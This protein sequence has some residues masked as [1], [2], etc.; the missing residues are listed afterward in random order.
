MVLQHAVRSPLT[1]L[2][3]RRTGDDAGR[4][5]KIWYQNENIISWLD[6]A[7]YVTVPDLICMFDLDEGM[8]QLNP[9]A[10]PGEHVRVI[11]LPAPAE[12][13]TRRGLEVFGPR[14]FGHE[15][16]YTPFCG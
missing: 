1:T 14:S 6:G 8:P 4:E 7:Y 2:S 9:F 13:R 16:D 11:A 12:W 15:V 5:L 3:A 10:G